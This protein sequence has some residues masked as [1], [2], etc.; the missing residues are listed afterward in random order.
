MEAQLNTPVGVTVAPDGG[1]IIADTRNFVI[2]H[3]DSSGMIE[4]VAGT[5][6]YEL[7]EASADRLSFNLV[8][9]SG[10]SWRQSGDLLVAEQYGQRILRLPN[11]WDDL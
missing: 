2:R 8:G 7:T 11:L 4:T 3:I 10:I 6:A 9:P 5:G 1:V